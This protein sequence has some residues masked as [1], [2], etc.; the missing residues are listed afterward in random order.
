M[1]KTKI[2]RKNN[3]SQIQAF[4][5]YGSA[6]KEN[7]KIWLECSPPGTFSAPEILAA[8]MGTGKQTSSQIDV[9]KFI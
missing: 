1:E 2:R 9:K 8:N 3:G 4:A 7:R 6:L 5:F